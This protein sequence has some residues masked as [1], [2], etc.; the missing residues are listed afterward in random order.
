MRKMK[1]WAALLCAVLMAVTLLPTQVWATDGTD[2]GSA[3]ALEEPIVSDKPTMSEETATDGQPADDQTPAPTD[4]ET[5][6]AEVP[7][8]SES[9]DPQEPEQEVDNQDTDNTDDSDVLC[10]AT[11]DPISHELEV[12]QFSA[13][14]A[15][16]AEITSA[17]L[18]NALTS[19]KSGSSYF[20]I[21]SV[22]RY[23]RA[24][25]A[26]MSRSTVYLK[27]YDRL[28][29]MAENFT[30]GKVS[31]PTNQKVTHDE[32]WLVTAAFYSD[33]PELFWA[34]PSFWYN[35]NTMLCS[36][37]QLNYNSHA[38]NL[39]TE[40]PLFLETAETI[41][42]SMPNGS[43]YE[44][45]LYLHDA[46]IKKVTYTYSKLEEQN[47][48]TTLVEGKGVCAGYAFALQY[49]LMRAGIQSY[50]V[51]GYAGENHAWNL[52]KID[53]EWY[54]VDA[55]WDDPLTGSGSDSAY[56]PFHTYFN[57]SAEMMAE[58]HTLSGQPYNVPLED[59]TA[60]DAF[61]HN[62]NHTAVSTSDTDLVS[63][64]ADLLQRNSGIAHLYVTD[65]NPVM[66]AR[67]WYYENIVSIARAM[68]VDGGYEYGYS[69]SGREIVLWFAGEFL[70]KTPGELNGSSGLDILDVELLY[71]YLTTGRPTITSVM[72]EAQFLDNADVNRDTII[73]VYDLQLL[74]E[75]VCNG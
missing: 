31:L 39:N 8:E 70:S 56:S 6:D 15:A 48:Y 17:E 13:E 21:I 36:E 20:D 16:D 60:T 32:A 69:Y 35:K 12:E 65:S 54:Y 52:A 44:K 62:V 9:A 61:Y 5:P 33:Y 45:E 3:A 30:V 55:T 43:D 34:R 74:Y 73:D 51:V 53:G 47:G 29:E 75:T 46:L 59:C 38:Y 24:K 7:E 1:R 4:D 28:L 68:Q 23:G 11:L 58:D 10:R 72:T 71:Q 64:V 25:L 67:E 50:Y 49:L 27:I 63:K 57:L 42:A 26:K 19:N 41:L 40:L 22:T 37:I 18:N 14:E 66:A 2:G